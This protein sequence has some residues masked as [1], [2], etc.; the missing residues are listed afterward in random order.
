MSLK[1][2]LYEMISKSNVDFSVQEFN[3]YLMI[4]VKKSKK[5]NELQKKINSLAQAALGYDNIDALKVLLVDGDVKAQ[6][7]Y[8]NYYLLRFPLFYGTENTISFLLENGF[9]DKWYGLDNFIKTYDFNNKGYFLLQYNARQE[10]SKLQEQLKKCR[11][12][13]KP[14]NYLKI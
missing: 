7:N 11:E 1:N 4:M 14:H 6:I 2:I 8:N 10:K 12:N 5:T 9:Y 13:I 3:R